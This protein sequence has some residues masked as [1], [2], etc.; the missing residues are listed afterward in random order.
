M[1]MVEAVAETAARA[2]GEFELITTLVLGLGLALSCGLVATKIR[3]PA[4]VGYLAAG[5]VIGS[6]L[7]FVSE[8]FPTLLGLKVDAE[9]FDQLAEIGV[10]L[11]MFGV[12]LHF[13]FKDLVAVRRIAVPGAIIQ[14]AVTICAASALAHA[15]DW[16]WGQSVVYGM[17]LSVASTVVLIRNMES[18]GDI[19]TIK[20]QIAVGW[21]VVEDL[22]T[23]AL[24]VLLPPLSGWL[25]GGA[26]SGPGAGELALALLK[27]FG[28]I[29][30]FAA[31]MLVV[32]KRTF[33]WLL[34][35]VARNGSHELFMISVI[36]VATGIAY[37][38]YALFDVSFALGAF[39]AGMI[40]KESPLATRAG[41]ESQPFRDVFSILFFVSV[42]MRF[43]PRVLLHE[44]LWLLLTVGVVMLGK[45]LVACAIMLVFRYPLNAALTVGAGLAQI[46]EFSFI[47]VALGKA[48]GVIE[49]DVQSLVVACAII[50]IALNSLVFRFVTPL[51]KRILSNPMLARIVDRPADPLAQLPASVPHRALT[52][53]VVVVGYAG[54][55]RRIVEYLQHEGIPFVVADSNRTVVEQ[56]REQGVH[57]VTGNVSEAGT[58]VQAHI[59]QAGA[60]VVTA[61]DAVDLHRIVEVARILR[62]EVKILV[63]STSA[64][65]ADRIEAE[66]LGRVFLE[67]EEI[68]AAMCREVGALLKGGASKDMGRK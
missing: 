1:A 53:H 21:L 5:I 49:P 13:S 15:L 20:G 42:G 62:P 34:W 32:G 7:P 27:T 17:A 24:L 23:V 3:L 2:T 41:R 14:T 12:G 45:P 29:A 68:S 48:L 65:E 63:R 43:D 8:R 56:L 36:A 52:G 44:P 58:L 33:P 60:L 4:L 61:T 57:A 46:G 55:G 51:Q 39:F 64:E 40:V 28:K 6:A 35:R 11:L 10:M 16:P 47:L 67:E 54:V 50:S 26:G 22:L 19:A 66:G 18:T 30:V 38:A 31:L 9:L 37:S 59:A 25:S